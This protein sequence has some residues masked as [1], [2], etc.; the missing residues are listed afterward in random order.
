MYLANQF[1]GTNTHAVKL[2]NTDGV[3]VTAYAGE[4]D[5]QLRLAIFNKDESH[6]LPLALEF[7]PNTSKPKY[8]D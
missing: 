2:K 1:T 7:H 4:Q 3:N 5:G 6:D 8:G